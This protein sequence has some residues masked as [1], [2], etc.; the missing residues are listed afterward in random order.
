MSTISKIKFKRGTKSALEA[1]LVGA[2]RPDAGEPVFELDTNKLKIG[3]GENDYADLPYIS[4]GSGMEQI[5][6]GSIYEFP[7]IGEENKLYVAK[8]TLNNYI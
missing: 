2:N 1:N 3:D 6:F 8:D 5:V 4:G 7:S